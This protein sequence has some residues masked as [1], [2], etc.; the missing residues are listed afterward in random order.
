MHFS[1]LKEAGA[2]RVFAIITHGILSGSAIEK[3][4]ASD[5]EAVVA[6]NTVPLQD[7]MEICS[8]IKVVILLI[9]CKLYHP[10]PF[11]ITIHTTSC[12]SNC[13]DCL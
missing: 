1:R 13:I 8:K 10:F 11:R 2:K 7:K 9:L 3:I 12:D 4:Q 6:T 5:L